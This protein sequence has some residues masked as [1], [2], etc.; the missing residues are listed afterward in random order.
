MF[1]FYFAVGESYNETVHV[2]LV[3]TR[4]AEPQSSFGGVQD[5]RTGGHWFDPWLGHSLSEDG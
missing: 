4:Y 1:L 5:L 2:T 3:L